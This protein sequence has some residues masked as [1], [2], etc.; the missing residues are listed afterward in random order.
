MNT[1]LKSAIAVGAMAFAS[2]AAAQITF[3]ERE[4]FQ[5]R[6]FSTQAPVEYLGDY[7]VNDRASSIVVTSRR[8]E[9]CEDPRFG[10]RCAY[11][12]PGQYPSLASM[13]LNNRVSSVRMVG[14]NIDD[15][16]Y[17]PP[18]L[19]AYDY[20]RRDS[21]A[22]F[23]APVIS[24]RAVLGAAEQRCWVERERVRSDA[25]LPGAIGGALI[26]GILGHEIGRG[27]GRDVAT[28]GGAV[29]GGA[30]GANIGGRGGRVEDVQRC[31]TVPAAA[32]AYWDVTYRFRG[33]DYRV[34][35]TNQPG[36]TV[37]VNDQGEPRV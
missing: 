15:A 31:E 37:L 26:G 17:A 16:R 24:V 2:Q 36:P 35:M 14:R 25:S 18:P 23:E 34:Q 8:W 5:G 29:V 10:G 11:V 4:N 21:E 1:I 27:G 9:I 32:P 22:L 7:G 12:R 6:A 20:G 33:L 28:V 30:I 19:A 3:Y 13:G